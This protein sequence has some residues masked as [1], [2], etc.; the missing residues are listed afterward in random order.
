M[1]NMLK[2]ILEKNVKMRIIPG[3]PDKVVYAL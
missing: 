2:N 1:M 3:A